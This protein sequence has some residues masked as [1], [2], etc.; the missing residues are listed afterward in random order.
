MAAA[1]IPAQRLSQGVDFAPLLD[2]AGVA[3][4]VGTLGAGAAAD[5]ALSILGGAAA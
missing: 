1:R 3:A 5:P 4:L 2:G